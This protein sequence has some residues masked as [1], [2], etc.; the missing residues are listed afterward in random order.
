L[1]QFK[2]LVALVLAVMMTLALV[3][4]A[5]AENG[6][7]TIKPP[8]GSTG[9]NSYPIYKVFDAIYTTAGISY[10]VMTGKTGVPDVSA[11][12]ASGYD[13][14]T[15][16]HFILDAAGNV[17]YGTED[18][19][20][21]ITDAAAG[22]EL[23]AEAIKAVAAY[24]AGD[25]PVTTATSTG[26]DDATASIPQDGYYYVATTTGTA[27]TI[28]SYR[29][30]VT[31]QDKNI[32]PSVDKTITGVDNT[33]AEIATDGKSADV[34]IG[35]IVTY[36]SVVHVKKGAINYVF[37]DKMSAG[38]TL[39]GTAPESITVDSSAVPSEKY[40]ITYS[41]TAATTANGDV[42]VG[43]NITIRFDND[44]VAG[45]EGKDIIITYK[46][47]LNDK[48]VIDGTA[49]NPNTIDLE[50][51][52]NPTATDEDEKKE[53]TKRTETDEAKVYT[54]AA[55]L[56]KVDSNKKPLAGAEFNVKGLTATKLGD[57][58]YQVTDYDPTS[59][60]DGTTLTCDPAGQ[61]VILGLSSKSVL[62]ATE[63]KAPDGYNKLV[64]SVTITPV[65]TGETI[66]K[67]PS[68]T[69]YY[70]AD[71]HLT[72]V[73]TEGAVTVTKVTYNLD[74][75]KTA[76]VV[77]NQAGAQL[78]ST[79]GIGTTIFYVVGLVLVLGAAAIVIARRK[80]EQ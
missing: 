60:A 46:A 43:D 75:V 62:S 65:K 42:E 80:A 77:V 45:L 36:Q 71:G 47:K 27:V 64:G 9:T 15:T 17:H 30:V 66:I 49:G 51:G 76:I 25:N 4:S 39:Q 34:N 33:S 12:M 2:T 14:T 7:I 63:T 13:K 11:Q 31:L 22:T 16:P 21:N 41:A 73:Q 57:G 40:S 32:V 59:T 58:E 24:I 44:Y 38:L 26:T 67:Q 72:D 52:H 70:D 48:A 3:G 56:Q 29:P 23:S 1:K 53:P 79:G 50:Y 5:M 20:G 78:P 37:H 8:T 68:T 6:T 10:S 35:D 28:D 18:N 55:A 54:Y 61:L 74:L 19:D 69:Y